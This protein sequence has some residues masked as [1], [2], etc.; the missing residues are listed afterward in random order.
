[1]KWIIVPRLKEFNAEHWRA[2]RIHSFNPKALLVGESFRNI[3]ERV[4]I[5]RDEGAM[6]PFFEIKKEIFVS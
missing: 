6:V 5:E 1:L 2:S 3:A 4:S